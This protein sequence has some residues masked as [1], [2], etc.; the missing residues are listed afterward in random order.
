MYIST[1]RHSSSPPAVTPKARPTLHLS[2]GAENLAKRVCS[3]YRT[4]RPPARISIRA[5]SIAPSPHRLID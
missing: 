2:G 3:R 1:S 5:T 4:P